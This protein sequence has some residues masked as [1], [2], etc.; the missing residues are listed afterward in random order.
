MCGEL[1]GAEVFDGVEGRAEV[2]VTPVDGVGWRV[3]AGRRDGRGRLTAIYLHLART[4][5]EAAEH[6]SLA[7]LAARLAAGVE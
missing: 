4:A 2:H 3:A 5:A 6:R 1:F 7:V